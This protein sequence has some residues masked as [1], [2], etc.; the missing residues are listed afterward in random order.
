MDSNS[1]LNLFVSPDRKYR[2]P[3]ISLSL[4][5]CSAM[6]A[7]SWYAGP[8]PQIILGHDLPA[9]LDCGWRWKFGILPHHDYYSYMGVLS[10]FLIALGLKLGGS[11]V[12]ALP[13]AVLIFSIC[14]LPPSIYVTFTRLPPFLAVLT[15]VS[16]MATALAPHFLRCPVEDLTYACVYN[17]WGYDLF[18]IALLP[19]MLAP[20][21]KAAWKDI[22]DG[23]VVGVCLV[24]SMFL[25]INFGLLLITAFFGYALISLR[26]PAYYI[27]AGISCAVAVLAVG[28]ALKWDF[29]A[30][31]HDM[32]MLAKVRAGLDP[33]G[34]IFNFSFL[35]PP[36]FLLFMLAILACA[37]TLV[38]DTSPSRSHLLRIAAITLGCA[39]YA[40]LIVM[41]NAPDGNFPECPVLCVGALI[42]LGE[43]IRSGA[44]EEGASRNIDSRLK[45][46]ALVACVPV[47]LL[48]IIL[49]LQWRFTTWPSIDVLWDNALASLVLLLLAPLCFI[50][51]WNNKLRNQRQASWM[52]AGYVLTL[53]VMWTVPVRNIRGLII[54][55]RFKGLVVPADQ[56]F[57]T[58]PLKGIAINAAGGDDTLPISYVNK[59]R[60]GL[61]LIIRT[62]NSQKPAA[63][64]DFTNPFNI[65]RGI[66]PL[67]GS[68]PCFQ[69]DFTI[70]KTFG[71]DPRQVFKGAEIVMIPKRNSL[72]DH[73][74]EA[75][76]GLYGKYLYEHYKIVAASQEWVLLEQK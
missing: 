43:I 46:L 42:L 70:S 71:P 41:S 29:P 10:C 3:M 13:T 18:L 36:L 37:K 11:F 30:Y 48:I 26:A 50:G 1:Y 63:T 4:A 72:G 22:A 68:P 5:L 9:L 60:D 59:I 51:T 56:A 49:A 75:V 40:V 20:P 21:D 62:G 65:A 6:I 66:R 16:L 58:G 14:I 57:E 7:S 2:W 35:S 54:A 34:F 23:L 33:E 38:F 24:L 32:R 67:S 17:R 45:R 12:M 31:V 52:A 69:V 15:S 53:A 27:A 8:I 73:S 25:K 61:N 39:F 76:I 55:L 19:I 64:L 47:V 44:V 74:L 28:W